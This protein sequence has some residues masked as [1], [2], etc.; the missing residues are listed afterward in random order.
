MI[1]EASGQDFSNPKR[2][3]YYTW[4]E[5]ALKF[6]INSGFTFETLDG[7]RTSGTLADDDF[8]PAIN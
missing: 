5:V 7:A 3:F 1:N 6:N 4:E 2:Q 8:T